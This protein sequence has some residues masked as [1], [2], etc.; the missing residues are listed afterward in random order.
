MARQVSHVRWV[1]ASI[2][3]VLFIAD[4]SVQS[5]AATVAP[6]GTLRVVFLG[7]NPVQ[8]RID[9]KTGEASGTVPDVARELAKRLGVPVSI[10][11]APNAGGVIGALRDGKADVGFLAYDE[12]RAREV[13]FGPAVVVMQNSYLVKATSPIKASADVDREGITIAAVKGQTQEHFVSATI[14]RAR[15]R[16]LDVM[17]PQAEVDTLLTSGEVHAFAINRQRSLEAEAAAA[18]RLRALPDSFLDVDQCVVVAN[19]NAGR[20]AVIEQLVAE[21]RASGFIKQSID[22]AKLVGVSVAPARKR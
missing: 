17:P 7:G 8:G 3:V 20:L 18:G 21:M 9:A 22:R 5:P 4:V 11:S 14:K 12:E 6:T 1:L 15:V 19:G 13:N 2:A 10:V 16:V